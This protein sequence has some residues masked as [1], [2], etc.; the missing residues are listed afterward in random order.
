MNEETPRSRSNDS[1]DE[2]GMEPEEYTDRSNKKP[3]SGL[4]SKK[5]KKIGQYILGKS[6]GE[7]TFGKV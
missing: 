2:M 7:G 5:N 3:E 4:E 1:Q 6:I